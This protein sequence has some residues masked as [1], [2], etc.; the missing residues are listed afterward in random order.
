[1]PLFYWNKIR[2]SKIKKEAVDSLYKNYSGYKERKGIVRF[3]FYFLP[4]IVA[5]AFLFFGI[6]VNSN[7]ANYFIMGITIFA[8]LFFSLLLVVADK[9]NVRKKDLI[10]NNNEE[11]LNYLRR[12]K[13]FSEHLI[14]QISYCIIIS[15]YL[16]ILMFL[17][18]LTGIHVSIDW[19]Y[20]KYFLIGGKYLLNGLIFYYGF[21]Y[22]ILLFVILSA[23][24]TMLFEDINRSR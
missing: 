18:Q 21:R 13:I 17:A 19:I 24:F 4:F 22:I 11:A 15:V 8:G 3:Y 12:Y 10:D 7:I 2:I 23:M 14:A 16:L 9:Y 1:M 20:L 5:I 6:K